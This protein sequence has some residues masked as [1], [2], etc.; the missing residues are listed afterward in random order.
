[1]DTLVD[2]DARISD[3]LLIYLTRGLQSVNVLI[4]FLIQYL[5]YAH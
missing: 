4:H 1:M 3:L 5:F 2:Q